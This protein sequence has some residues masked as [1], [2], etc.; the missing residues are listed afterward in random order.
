VSASGLSIPIYDSY[1]DHTDLG[2]FVGGEGGPDG[3]IVSVS[4]TVGGFFDTE[5][6]VHPVYTT[7]T[8]QIRRIVGA[9]PLVM[10]QASAD[11]GMCTRIERQPL[12]NA[13]GVVFGVTTRSGIQ[14]YLC[15]DYRTGPCPLAFT[16]P[17]QLGTPFDLTY[18]IEGFYITH[19]AGLGLYST[20]DAN[21]I[22][23]IYRDDRVFTHVR[24]DR[25]WRRSVVALAPAQREIHVRQWDGLDLGWSTLSYPHPDLL[26]INDVEIVGR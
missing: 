4:Y 11:D 8:H 16:L 17:G 22:P 24:C 2:I 20:M 3:G 23:E 5:T 9:P 10:G 1:S 15:D 13:Y 25:Q 21:A 18:A 7:P 14:I 19:A 6:V 12:F 26:D